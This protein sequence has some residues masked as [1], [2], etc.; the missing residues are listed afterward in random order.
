MT[1]SRPFVDQIFVQNMLPGLGRR[2]VFARQRVEEMVFL[3]C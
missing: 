3:R 1:I 2:Y